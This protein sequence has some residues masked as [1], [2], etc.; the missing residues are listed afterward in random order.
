[1]QLHMSKPYYNLITFYVIFLLFGSFSTSILPTYFLEQ[2]LTLNQMMLGKVIYFFGQ[3]IFLF[4]LKN[5]FAKFSWRMALVTSIAYI[6]LI[7]NLQSLVP[8]YIGQ[9]I[10]GTSLFFFFV[11]YNIAHFELT[12]KEKT[13][14]S[15]ALMFILPSLVSIF[16]PLAA[17]YLAQLNIIFIW[18]ISTLL[19]IVCFYLVKYQTDF[20]VVYSI[21]QSLGEI[22]TTRIFIFLEGLWEALPFGIIPI[23]TLFFIK[24]PLPFG[25]YLSYLSFISIVAN[26]LLGRFSDKIRKRVIFLYP[27]TLAIAIVTFLFPLSTNNLIVWVFLTTLLQ[28]LIPIFW[29]V[30][31]AFF[32][33]SHTDLKKTIPGREIVLAIGRL[34][35][36][37]L[38]FI[39]FT[40]EKQP[41]YIFLVLGLF[42]L[43]YP[44]ILY[45]RTKI[46][47]SHVYL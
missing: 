35:G 11:F 4:T 2:G 17:G 41:N 29:N 22:K 30:S 39:S 42:M 37:A 32:V 3:L 8:F 31:T 7:I 19:F 45:I 38:A 36:L 33:D 28:L 5:L 43:L 6:F 26:F 15:S 24:E 34:I 13:A 44:V 12:P 16:A 10:S 47:K 27:I 9:F 18:I 1:M 25:L 23:Y 40:I 20:Q 46:R 14:N 21:K